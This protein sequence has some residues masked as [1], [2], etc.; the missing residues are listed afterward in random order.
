M[1]CPRQM[2]LAVREQH[3]QHLHCGPHVLRSTAAAQ[4]LGADYVMPVSPNT[5]THSPIHPC[6][7]SSCHIATP[8]AVVLPYPSEYQMLLLGCMSPAAFGT[9]HLPVHRM[10]NPSQPASQLAVH[11]HHPVTPGQCL[12]CPLPGSFTVLVATIPLCIHLTKQR[13]L[14]HIPSVCFSLSIFK[15]PAYCFMD[16]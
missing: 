15:P 13:L 1:D 11:T 16:N 5:V 9:M 7:Y 3:I 12:V 10:N 6:M 8:P 14:L 4:S 2:G